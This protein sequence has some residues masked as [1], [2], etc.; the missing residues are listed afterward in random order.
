MYFLEKIKNEVSLLN[1]NERPEQNEKQAAIDYV[2]TLLTQAKE[3]NKADD[4]NKL[5]E[6]IRLLNSKKYGLVWE[7]HAEKV[8]EEMKTKI[9]VFIEDSSR[10]IQS[11]GGTIITSY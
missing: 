10:R 9:P 4:V 1:F 11:G 2:N 3:N 8:E 6:I 5:E 7:H